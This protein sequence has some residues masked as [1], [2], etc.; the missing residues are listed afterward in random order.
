MWA[1]SLTKKVNNDKKRESP[2]AF[3]FFNVCPKTKTLV[4]FRRDNLTAFVHARFQVNM[5][6]TAQLARVLVFG[7]AVGAQR[8][9]R[10]TH[11]TA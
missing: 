8:V 11:I 4:F 3:A 10:T 5:V 7:V 1:K 6:R 9:M 2:M